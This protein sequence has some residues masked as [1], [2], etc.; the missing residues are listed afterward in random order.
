MLLLDYES[1]LVPIKAE[2]ISATNNIASQNRVNVIIAVVVLLSSF[3]VS[4]VISIVISWPMER[5]MNEMVSLALLD[6][7]T[8]SSFIRRKS[9]VSEISH[10]ELSCASVA[11]C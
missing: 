9:R 10:C 7:P 2:W 5:L 3:V 8:T 1:R 6:L 4:A 11:R